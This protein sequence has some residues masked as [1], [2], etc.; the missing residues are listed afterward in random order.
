MRAVLDACVLYPTV[1]REILTDP[2]VT[3]LYVPI[4]T[5]RLREE[6]LRAAERNGIRDLAGAEAAMLSDRIP[7]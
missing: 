3:A 6:W 7:P 2:A 5:A 4:W 1:L